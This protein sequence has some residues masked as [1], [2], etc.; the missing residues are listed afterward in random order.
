[1]AT[2]I[3]EIK[4]DIAELNNL[5][6]QANRQRIKDVL[7]LEIRKLQT[8]IETAK[9][10]EQKNSSTTTSS[11]NTAQKCY[12]VKLNNYGWDQTN[13]TMKIYI[14]LSNVHQLPKEAIVCNF[15]EKSLDLRIFGLDNKNYHL[16]INNLC[17]EIDI[18]KSNFKVKTD[19]IVVSLAKKIAKEWS[20]VTLVEKRIKD[21]K[22]PSMPELG[23]DTDPS[24]SLM[25]LMKKMYQDGDD[26]T[27]KTIAKAWTE[28]QEKQRNGAS[29]DL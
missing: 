24:A 16:P 1:M 3:D 6:K 26:E 8:Q 5:L 19:M 17:A 18:E 27:K 23:E 29:L 13:T 21:A 4:L 2:K 22:S 10:L 9:L 28:S 20:H 11:L 7:T 25:N 15:T 14:T 12:E